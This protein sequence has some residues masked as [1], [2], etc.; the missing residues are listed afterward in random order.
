[1]P[2]EPGQLYFRRG[3]VREPPTASKRAMEDIYRSNLAHALFQVYNG[4]TDPINI[5]TPRLSG[6]SC[7]ALARQIIADGKY[8]E[9]M[10]QLSRTGRDNDSK[11]RVHEYLTQY[12][13]AAHSNA[14]T[15]GGQMV[16][17]DIRN[18]FFSDYYPFIR[19]STALC[20]RTKSSLFT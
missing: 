12:A 5:E 19:P 9:A 1:M 10:A 11:E 6:Q 4:T 13:Q 17:L 7:S 15:N 14:T 20:E 16:Y 2:A 18:V 8:S 3:L